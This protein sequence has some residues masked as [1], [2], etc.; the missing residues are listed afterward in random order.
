MSGASPG[1]PGNDNPP[2]D[3][4]K[5]SEF[6]KNIPEEQR[7]MLI[8]HVKQSLTVEHFSGPLPSADEL[9]KYAPEVQRIIVNESVENRIHRTTLEDRGQKMYFAREMI[10][11]L[12]GFV[13]ALIMIIGSIQSVQSGYGVEGL[14]GIGGAVTGI[15]G[16]FLFT[17][18]KKR[19]DRRERQALGNPPT[20]AELSNSET[21][22]NE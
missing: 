10:G 1:P 21:K 22:S 19:S 14:I 8:Q 15:A 9:A 5:K 7:D 4:G 2:P 13:L 18:Y 20:R 17:D 6:I 12:F 11:L 16:T 3:L